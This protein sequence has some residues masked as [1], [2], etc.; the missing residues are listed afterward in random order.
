MIIEVDPAM[1]DLKHELSDAKAKIQELENTITKEPTMT[2][3]Q[4]S[5]IE[6]ILAVLQRKQQ[7]LKA[8]TA[9]I[10]LSIVTD[11]NSSFDSV[12]EL[13]NAMEVTQEISSLLDTLTILN[14]DRS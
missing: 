9:K 12:A 1:I 3:H 14:N 11:H 10:E 5:E 2:P 7:T 6:S 8:H 13:H 4:Q